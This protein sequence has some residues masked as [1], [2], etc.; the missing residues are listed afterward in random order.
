MELEE[1]GS[2]CQNILFR[3]HYSWKRWRVSNQL[4]M[5]HMESEEAGLFARFVE[6][7]YIIRV[8]SGWRIRNKHGTCTYGVGG[9]VGSLQY[10]VNTPQP[11]DRWG[12]LIIK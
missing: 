1:V 10:N 3:Q 12:I 11:M 5:S 8:W 9:R 4:E 2:L 7:G 6:I